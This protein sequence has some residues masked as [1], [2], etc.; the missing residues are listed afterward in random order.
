MRLALKIFG[1][2]C[3]L[4]VASGIILLFT[5]A[6]LGNVLLGIGVIVFIFGFAVPFSIEKASRESRKALKVST[7]VLLVSVGTIILG[8]FFKFLHLPGAAIMFYS[9]SFMIMVYFV[10]FARESEGRKLQLRKDRQLAAILFTDIVGFTAMMGQDEDKALGVLEVNRKTQKKI[11]RKHRGKWLKEMGDGSLVVFYTA[12]EAVTA[13]IEIQKRI[14][15]NGTFNVRMGIHISEI[16]FTDKDVFG[17]GVNVASRISDK[18]GANEICISDPVYQNIRN[19]E[20]LHI[21]PLG[22]VDL[23]NVDYQLNIHKIEIDM[24]GKET[25]LRNIAGEL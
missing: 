19:R 20:D 4:L 17:D 23:K 12:T 18:A 5:G 25:V 14:I 21:S 24:E 15:D 6:P 9:G 10:F 3:I 22:A 13:A 16:V 1:I 11:I 8:G 7:I 2:L